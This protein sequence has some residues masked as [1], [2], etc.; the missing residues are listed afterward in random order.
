MYSS[1]VAHLMTQQANFNRT[2]LLGDGPSLQGWFSS[3]VI[4]CLNAPLTRGSMPLDIS[5]IGSSPFSCMSEYITE[6]PKPPEGNWSL[7]FFLLLSLFK[8]HTGCPYMTVN[9]KL[10]LPLPNFHFRV[11]KY[12]WDW[13]RFHQY[14]VYSICDILNR[15]MPFRCWLKW[16]NSI[17]VYHHTVWTVPSSFCQIL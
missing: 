13:N 17:T 6:K 5:S 1:L 15:N 4:C 9:K 8:L 10:L 14:L 7:I 3:Y 12:K 11:N 2:L 16:Y